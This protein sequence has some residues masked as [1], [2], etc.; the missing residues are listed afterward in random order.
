MSDSS[1]TKPVRSS[2]HLDWDALAAYARPRLRA[3]LGER[4]DESSPFT[5]EQFPGGHSNLTYLLRFGGQEFVMRRPPFG[6]LALKAHDMAREYRV[7]EAVHAVFPLAP[8]PFVLCEDESVLGSIFYIMERR[9]GMVVRFEEPP[10]LT[11]RPDERR[12]VSEAMVAALAALHNVDISAPN[13]SALGKPSGFVERQVSGWTERWKRSQTSVLAEMD[14]LASWLSAHLPS[15]PARPTLVHG[16]FKLD[17]VMLDKGDPGRIVAVFD[18]EMSAIG[19]PLVDLGILLCYWVH[20]A[21]ASQRDA[22]T[23]VTNRPG[24]FTRAEILERYVARTGFDL[25]NITFYEVFAVFKL[26]VVLQQIF[27]RY[28]QGQTDDPRFATLDERVMWLARI[29]S[30]L[31]EKS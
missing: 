30:A 12:R 2:E 4:F 19:D 27:F 11:N 1:D 5:V 29:G 25:T 28:H 8:R 16:D 3:T 15:D 7:L 17:N 21:T 18:W 6:P 24:W 9:H 23:S 10:E 13:L 31:L 26:T 20:T 14:M 22:L